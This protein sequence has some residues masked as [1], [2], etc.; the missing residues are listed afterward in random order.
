MNQIIVSKKA[1]WTWRIIMIVVAVFLAFDG[2]IHTLVIPQV[3]A[4]FAQLNI[5]LKLSLPMGIIELVSLGLYCVPRSSVLG[6]IL[7]TGYL[8]GAVFVNMTA[9]V[10]L[11]GNILF[12]VY[13]GILLWGALYILEPRMRALLPFKK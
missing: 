7:L 11:F 9:G 12:P 13:V 6:A 4:S 1:L 2:I 8:G 3:A 5:P 10:S